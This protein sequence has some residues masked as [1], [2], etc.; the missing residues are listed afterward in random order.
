L[1]KLERARDHLK[2]L[3]QGEREFFQGAPARLEGTYSDDRSKYTFRFWVDRQPPG[4]PLPRRRPLRRPLVERLLGLRQAREGAAG[5]ELDPQ[6]AVKAL[7]LARGG[8]E[9][10][11]CQ[12]MVDA[13]LPAEEV[14]EHRPAAW[15]T[16]M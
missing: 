5:V 16:S 11:L 2:A 3:Q 6:R 10:R 13:I 8:G 14:E 12:Q 7:D 15:R 4:E 9:S 1:L